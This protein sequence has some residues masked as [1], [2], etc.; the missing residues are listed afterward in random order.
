MSIYDVDP[1]V[2]I[3]NLA[4]DLKEIIKQ[5]E[6]TPYVKTGNHKQRPPVDKDWFFI[7]AAAVL[8]TVALRGPIGVSKLRTKYGGKKNKGYKPEGFVKGSGNILR[9]AL[10]E[11]DKAGLTIQA[12]KGV[13]KGRIVT[14]K[15]MKMLAK[16][17][18]K[19][20]TH[21]EKSTK[22]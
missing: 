14:P 3:N 10:Q 22:E 15:G 19:D 16:A 1:Q 7:R 8:R 11:L 17:G 21:K 20:T 12:E 5:P 4:K 18:F 6:W 13:H 9:K 2:V